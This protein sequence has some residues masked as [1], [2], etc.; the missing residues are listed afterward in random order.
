MS[1][2]TELL[3]VGFAGAGMGVLGRLGAGLLLRYRNAGQ[4]SAL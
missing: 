4:C 1:G 2:L 3:G